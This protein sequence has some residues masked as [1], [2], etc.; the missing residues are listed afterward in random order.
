MGFFLFITGTV[1]W[2]KN[3][4]HVFIDVLT[5]QFYQ[6]QQFIIIIIIIIIVIIIQIYV[7]RRWSSHRGV[8]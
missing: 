5:V 2:I 8:L 4:A 3:G 6:N 7:F 1:V